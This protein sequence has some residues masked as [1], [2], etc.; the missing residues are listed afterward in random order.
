MPKEKIFIYDKPATPAR[1]A[2]WE[3]SIGIGPK[4]RARKR[5]M[6]EHVRKLSEQLKREAEARELRRD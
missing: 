6:R 3:E 2:E 1:W 4:A 5:E